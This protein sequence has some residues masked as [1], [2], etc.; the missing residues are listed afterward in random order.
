VRF[1]RN[2]YSVPHTHVRKLV[3][4]HADL[5]TVRISS[6]DEVI[7][8][9]KRSFDANQTIEDR[10]HIE[11]LKQEKKRA[12]KARRTDVVLRA[13]PSAE[14]F[15][16]RAIENRVGAGLVVRHLR[17]FTASYGS[18]AVER[19]ICEALTRGVFHPHG[20]RHILETERI[21]KGEPAALPIDLPDDQRVRDLHV[22]P[23][24]LDDY[25]GLTEDG[26]IDE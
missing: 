19:A 1:D 4:V 24:S 16:K 25:D 10:D 3:V 26:E 15:L 6:G 12:G 20:L 9:H 5:D 18:R 17:S 2:D 11:Q 8:S 14:K 22:R 21:R 7:A 13:V 23:H